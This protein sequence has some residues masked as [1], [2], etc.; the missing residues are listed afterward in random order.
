MVDRAMVDRAMVDRAMVDRANLN[1]FKCEIGVIGGKGG[2]PDATP[3]GIATDRGGRTAGALQ[4]RGSRS[5]R[6]GSEEIEIRRERCSERTLPG[7][8]GAGAE[9]IAAEY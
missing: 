7:G 1:R 6:I 2:E 9:E 5:E 3:P 8:T 4:A